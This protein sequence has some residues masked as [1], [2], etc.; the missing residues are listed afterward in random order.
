MTRV[1][2]PGGHLFITLP[3]C[4]NVYERTLFFLTGNSSRYKVERPDRRHSHI[5]MLPSHVLI[6]LTKRAGLRL[7]DMRSGFAFLFGHFWDG[8]KH[9]LFAYNLMYHYVRQ[10]GAA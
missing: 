9:P 7:V 1:L 5:S 6:N 10:E 8:L 3:S 4:W 2:A